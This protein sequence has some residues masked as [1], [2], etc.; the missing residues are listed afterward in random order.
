MDNKAYLDQIAVKSKKTTSQPIF[1]PTVIKL[2]VTSLIVLILFVVVFSIFNH[3]NFERKQ[4]FAA[5]YQRT[6]SLIAEEAPLITYDEE[7]K[8][9][10]LRQY[11]D[12]FF[13]SLS[14]F[15]TSYASLVSSG[16]LN[17]GNASNKVIEADTLNTAE[18]TNSLEEG[19]LNGIIDDVYASTALYQVSV[20]I[21]MNQ[22]ALNVATNTEVANLITKFNDELKLIQENYRKFTN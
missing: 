19:Y 20:L 17:V 6:T 21:N 8:S 14:S 3:S 13:T 11:N 9:A 15:N 16:G 5:I 1:T 4:K 10:T 2:L 22:E 12:M 7:L 18:I